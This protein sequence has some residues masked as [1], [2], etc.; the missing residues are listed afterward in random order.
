MR[1]IERIP[2]AIRGV[3]TVGRVVAALQ[4]GPVVVA[5]R[6]QLVHRVLHTPGPIIVAA[7]ALGMLPRRKGTAEDLKAGT[8]RYNLAARWASGGV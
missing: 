3:A 4:V 7:I 5:H 1:I 8:P 6:V 2:V